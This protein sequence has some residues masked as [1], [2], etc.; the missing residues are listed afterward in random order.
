MSDATVPVRVNIAAMRQMFRPCDPDFIRDVC[1]AKCCRSTT[2]P[3]GIAVTVTSA[4]A[5]RLRKRGAV[6]DDATGRIEPVDRHCPFEAQDGS[7]L[8]TIHADGEEPL[9][10]VI[11]PFTVNANGT[12]IVRNR[13]RM[14]PC[15]K[16]PGAQFVA[17][18]H[19][20]S[21]EYVFG[22]ENAALV[23]RLVEDERNGDGDCVTLPVPRAIV[24]MLH[25][26]NHASKAGAS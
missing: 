23:I 26:K 13:Y 20:R 16:A 14:L 22:E 19:R 12:L 25:H 2:D 18:A 1:H 15:F 7:H 11:S 9:G 21:L 3:T 5:V 17:V 6:I 4:E 10:C 24:R 8:C